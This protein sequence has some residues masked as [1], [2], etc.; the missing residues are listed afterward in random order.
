MFLHWKCL[1]FSCLSFSFSEELVFYAHQNSP[2]LE[3]SILRIFKRNTTDLL[4]VTVGHDNSLDIVYNFSRK[5]KFSVPSW[6]TWLVV[7]Y[8]IWVWCRKIISE[9]SLVYACRFIKHN[10]GALGG[11]C[12]IFVWDRWH[13]KRA[14]NYLWKIFRFV[15]VRKLQEIDNKWESYHSWLLQIKGQAGYWCASRKPPVPVECV[16]P[17]RHL[18]E[19]AGPSLLWQTLQGVLHM[20]PLSLQGEQG[21]MSDVNTQCTVPIQL[22]PSPPY[23]ISLVSQF[24]VLSVIHFLSFLASG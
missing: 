20:W 12:Y 16:R 7:C 22:H 19:T 23:P 15:N 1:E 17:G 6:W 24:P 14:V 13:K 21:Y 9:R 5:E 18:G 4:S 10:S 2:P 8:I 11:E 3:A